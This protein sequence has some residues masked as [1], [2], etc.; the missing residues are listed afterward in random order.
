MSLSQHMQK[1]VM[2]NPRWANLFQTKMPPGFFEKKGQASALSTFK[3]VAARVPAYKDL[4]KKHHI[5]P[6]QINTM[7]DFQ[8]LPVIDKKNYLRAYPLEDLCLDGNLPQMY[9][10]SVSSGS[11]G[12]PFFWPMLS[13]QTKVVPSVMELFYTEFFGVQEKSTLMLI[14]LS[15]GTWTAGELAAE[16]S[17][18]VARNKKYPLTVVTPGLDLDETLKIIKKLGHKYQQTVF[19]AYPPF[20]RDLLEIGEKANIDWPSLNVKI[21]A[22]GEGYSE[23]WRDWVMEKIGTEKAIDVMNLFGTAD[24]GIIGFETPLS[25]RLRRAARTDK[26]LARTLFGDSNNLPVVMQYNPMA[27]YFEEKDGELIFTANLGLPLVRYNIHDRGGLIPFNSIPP[28]FI[29]P[30]S[31]HLP[32]F[33]AFGRADAATLYGVNIYTEN[34][35]AALEKKEIVRTNTGRFKFKTEYDE[36]QAQT[37]SIKVE[38]KKTIKPSEE[39]TRDYIQTIVNTLRQKNSEY[40]RLSKE[41]AEQVYPRVNLFEFGTKNFAENAKVKNKYLDFS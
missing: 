20:L 7:V 27:R 34:I 9:T 40:K 30:N 5:D 15:L 2:G 3:N 1:I 37:L 24:A 12:E 11:T 35:Q 32:C 23:E 21:L 25:I 14:T 10:L 33:Y 4:L 22:G 26:Q 6:A 39:L 18:I 31:W 8:R 17:R 29:S 13:E 28:R 38:L 16:A 36:N 41:K 19:V